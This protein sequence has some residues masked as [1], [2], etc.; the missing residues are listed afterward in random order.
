MDDDDDVPDDVLRQ[1][2]MDEAF[3]AKKVYVQK[4]M[5]EYPDMMPADFWNPYLNLKTW[6]AHDQDTTRGAF[7][8]DSDTGGSK[9]TE[10]YLRNVIARK[11]TEEQKRREEKLLRESRDIWKPK[12]LEGTTVAAAKRADEELNLPPSRLATLSELPPFT[13]SLD[14]VDYIIKSKH[15]GGMVKDLNSPRVIPTVDEILKDGLD[16]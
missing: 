2:R 11:T 6:A 12:D 3:E 1:R 8:K 16:T 15:L 4:F 5:N 10:Q 14:K 13:G 9:N 7:S